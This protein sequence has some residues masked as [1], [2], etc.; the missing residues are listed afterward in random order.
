M[1]FQVLAGWYTWRMR[2]VRKPV[3]T[4]AL[5]LFI[6]GLGFADADHF[7][8]AWQD[9]ATDPAVR[10]WNPKPPITDLRSAALAPGGAARA[11][12]VLAHLEFEP[13]APVAGGEIAAV[14]RFTDRLGR[15]VELDRAMH[16]IPLHA[17]AVRDDLAGEMVHMHPLRQGDSADWH[18]MIIFPSS[19][20]WHMVTQGHVGDTLYEF[21]TPL[22]V[23]G[24]REKI[25]A[26]ADGA[27]TRAMFQYEVTLD[28][29]P[30]R[31]DPG[32]PAR[33]HFTVHH[34]P[35]ITKRAAVQNARMRH[36]LIMAG[37]GSGALWNHHG[38]GS[39]DAIGARAPVPVVRKF[40]PDDPFDY[41]IT[42]PS[43][44]KWLIDFEY[45]GESAQ[46]WI[47]VQEPF[48][49]PGL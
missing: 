8:R 22:E 35:E 5:S 40:S 24:G 42:F 18:D 26:P 38:D 2:P 32:I 1:F 19:G 11:G 20:R 31:I 29:M 34:A 28:G 14:W 37:A 3:L 23:A 45:M 30:P 36:N 12:D 16:S 39:I 47:N 15:P 33:L 49:V 13:A 9:L 46:F 21:T 10:D 17:Y 7:A 4:A 27:R 43:P 41:E 6:L 48:T 44:G 25:P